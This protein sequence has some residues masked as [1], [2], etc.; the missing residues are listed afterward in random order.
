MLYVNF[1]EKTYTVNTKDPVLTLL[2]LSQV[3]DWEASEILNSARDRQTLKLPP[4]P[5]FGHPDTCPED[6]VIPSYELDYTPA[7]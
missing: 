7:V 1:P 5:W 4:P 6:H 3:R 2:L